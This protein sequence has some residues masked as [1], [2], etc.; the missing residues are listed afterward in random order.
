MKMIN[1]VALANTKYHKG[2][3]LLSGIAII[4]TSVLVF[5]ITSIGL[6]VV[7][8]QNAAV[9][10]V[11]PTWHAM[12]RQVSEENMGKIAQHDLIGE[13]GLRQDVG[14]SVL[15][16]DDFVLI[17]YLDNGA[18]KLAKQTFTKGHAPKKGNDAVLSRDALKT[19][20]YP[21]AKIGDTIKIPIQIYEADGMGLQQ[22]KTFR[23][24]GF[25]PDIKNQNDEKIF[26]MLVSKDFMEEVIPKKHR[27]YR[28]MIR[29]NET[30]ATSTD[31]IKEQIKEIG[32]NFDV[33]EDNIVENSDYL[34]ANYIDPAF[35][36]GMAIIVGI[37]LIAGA[38]T[39]YSIY[40]VSLINKVQEFGKLAALGATKRQ[41]RQ[42]IL[43]ENLIVAGLSIPAGLL[44]GIAAV[45]FVFF[46]LISS[47]SS[48]QAMTKEMRQVLDNGEVSLILPWI[49]AMTIG[50]T[51]LTVILASL[52]PMRQASKIMPIEAMRYTGQ[53]QGNKKQRKGFIDLNLRRLANANLSRN[54]KRTMVTIF[55]L[56]MIGI[57][58]VVISTVF[59]CMN[60]KQAA[61]DTIAEDYCMS[62]ASREGDK[63]RPELKW[64]VIQQNNPLNNKVINKIKAIDGVEKVDAFQS[65]T[66]EVPSV[67]DPGTDKPMSLSIGGISKD[68]MALINRDIEKGHATYEELNSGDKVIAT[69]YILA[70]YPE[71]KIG[72]T[73]T[74]KFFDGNRTFEKD[75]TIIGGGSFAQSVTNFDNFLM[76]NEAI[77]K[78]SKNNLTY[79]VNIKAAK[80]KTKTVQSAIENIEEGNELFRLE[81][82][83]EVLKQWEDT[84]Q[85]TAGAG[86]AIML[87]LAIVGIMNLINTTIDSILSRKKELGVMQ[88]IGMSNQQM[89]KMLRTEGFVYAGGIIL[90]AGGL[91]SI[92][93][94]LVYLYAESHSLMQIKVYQ[95]PLIQVLLMIFLVVIVQL[96]LTYATTTI[97]NKETVIKRIQA[98]E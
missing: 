30:A 80:G 67:K 3:N 46:Q 18:Q 29:L 53:M 27:S 45:K 66:G 6:G 57:L 69:G 70:N 96:I 33:T 16:K 11:Y 68:Q 17:S 37:I 1:R 34:F 62:I 81:S 32:K 39:I 74:F 50:V 48:E 47:I 52:K 28:M 87:V 90:L 82:Y 35:Y 58:F 77:K 95:Y 94:Y 42:I 54:K 60:P 55:S 59:S 63:M 12:Y 19:L 41:I 61:R 15:N 64:T 36:S 7:N 21:N 86:Y 97:V 26:S 31:A 93:G 56:G 89:K 49:I 9:N 72:D 20:G 14:E 71:I 40:Y 4:L 10:K 2:K 22:E 92:L 43:R 13:Y 78:L 25:S 51:L 44:I 84:L 79:Y 73:L 38:L 88:A 91:G 75:M 83:E 65:I 8:V 76:S 23:L 5:L 24:T 85:L 98:S